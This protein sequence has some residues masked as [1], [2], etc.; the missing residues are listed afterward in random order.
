MAKQETLHPEWLDWPQTRALINAFSDNPSALRFVGGA[1]RDA[2]LGRGVK[3]VDAATTCRPEE[4]MTL[5]Q[6]AGIK[7]IPT[8]IAH[9]TVTAVVEGRQF[10]ITTLRK[11]TA[12]DGRHADVQYTDSWQEDAQ[13]RDFTMNALYLSVFGEMYDYVGGIEDAREGRVVFIG[14]AGE[15]IQED[16]LR[17]LR[18]FRFYAHYG[19][20]VA[21]RDARKACAKYA[22]QIARLS[23]ERI[24][25]EML[26]LLA[27]DN[28]PHTLEL[29]QQCDVLRHALGFSVKSLEAFVR[30]Q[31]IEKF[32]DITLRPYIKIAL[33]LMASESDPLVSCKMLATHWK[34]SNIMAH[35]LETIISKHEAITESLSDAKIKHLIRTLGQKLFIHMVMLR[36]AYGQGMV[37]KT[38]PYHEMLHLVQRWEIPVFPVTGQDLIAAGFKPGY[39]MGDLLQKL[40]DAWEASNYEMDKSALIAKAHALAS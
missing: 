9:G 7:A 16:Y 30:L 29:M 32:S 3:D 8:G 21:D 26:K 10:E 34:L 24:Q 18:F 13:R 14:D 20:G 39:D 40:E 1:V 4:T 36:W 22:A 15:R 37:N 23:G 12:C 27:A 5:L 17:I 19:K 6:N 38:H 28:A 31:D 2:V 35:E 25:S 11:D 33:F